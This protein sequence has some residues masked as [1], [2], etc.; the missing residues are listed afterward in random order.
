MLIDIVKE[1]KRDFREIKVIEGTFC[2]SNES[3]RNW[4]KKPIDFSKADLINYSQKQNSRWTALAISVRVGE[5]NYLRL[6][7]SD[8]GEVTLYRGSFEK[9]YNYFIL[10]FIRKSIIFKR[11]MSNRER[12]VDDGRVV[13][14]PIQVGFKK[15]LNMGDIKIIK[16]SLMKKYSSAVIHAGN[17]ILMMQVTDKKDGSSF[18]IFASGKRLKITPLLKSSPISLTELFHNISNTLPSLEIVQ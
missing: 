12:R 17:P 16:E 2:K 18:D 11:F 8:K 4:K 13:V 7:I 3:F 9:F 1:S 10:N 5:E 6:R 14:R 15:E